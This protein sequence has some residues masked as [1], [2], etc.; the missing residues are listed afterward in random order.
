MIE[1]EDA[2]AARAA[3]GEVLAQIDSDEIEATGAQRAFIAGAVAGLDAEQ[4]EQSRN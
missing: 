2:R 4:T 3:L 1:P